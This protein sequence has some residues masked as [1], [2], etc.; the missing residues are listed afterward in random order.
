LLERFSAAAGLCRRVLW[1]ESTSIFD[2]EDGRMSSLI[3]RAAEVSRFI[4][5]SILRKG[6][7]VVM[8]L[9]WV[10]G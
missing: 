9:V 10:I 4:H 8:V 3:V 7:S 1:I 2:Q 6:G 5:V